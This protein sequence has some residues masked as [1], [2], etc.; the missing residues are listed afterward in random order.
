MHA[1]IIKLN[2]ERL[3]EGIDTHLC[4]EL[5]GSTIDAND[6]VTAFVKAFAISGFHSSDRKQ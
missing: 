4:A 3:L 1:T 6:Q 2:V 5:I